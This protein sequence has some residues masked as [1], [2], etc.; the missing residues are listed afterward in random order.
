MAIIAVKNTSCHRADQ[1]PVHH[2]SA[3]RDSAAK[4]PLRSGI[5]FPTVGRVGAAEAASVDSWKARR[6]NSLKL[7]IS[8]RRRD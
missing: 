2:G 8:Y 1:R 6:K 4:R 7:D 3:A 5:D